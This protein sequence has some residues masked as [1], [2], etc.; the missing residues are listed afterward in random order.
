MNVECPHCKTELDAPDEL[1]GKTAQCPKCNR[2]FTVGAETRAAGK[3]IG[4]IVALCAVSVAGTALGISLIVSAS[5]N[6]RLRAANGT[7]AAR[8]ETMTAEI[9]SAK[10][11]ATDTRAAKAQLEKHLAEAKRTA[12]QGN[13]ESASSEKLKATPQYGLH[14]T[15]LNRVNTDGSTA[16]FSPSEAK[17]LADS[18]GAEVIQ[19]GG[20]FWSSPARVSRGDTSFIPG[21]RFW[22]WPVDDQVFQGKDGKLV[23]KFHW[24]VRPGQTPPRKDN[25]DIFAH[26]DLLSEGNGSTFFNFQANRLDL[27]VG[28]TEGVCET[29]LNIEHLSGK[30]DVILFLS[31]AMLF[32]KKTDSNLLHLVATLRKQR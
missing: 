30:G 28:Q 25:D 15:I 18:S 6:S 7:L 12:S 26:F 4:L 2:P 29:T 20:Q 27:N 23:I 14:T 5:A 32:P 11:D 3:P 22:V 17:K 10:K 31:G 9:D 13:T 16:A 21:D 8:I 24:R 19:K 1:R